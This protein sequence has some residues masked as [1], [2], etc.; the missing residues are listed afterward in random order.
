MRVRTLLAAT[1]TLSATLVAPIAAQPVARPAPRLGVLAGAS[2]A[3]LSGDPVDEWGNRTGFVAGAALT[4]PLTS[5]VSFQPEVLFAQKGAALS[6]DGFTATFKLDY[7]EVPLLL[8]VDMPTTGSA[9]RP[10]LFAGPALAFKASCDVEASGQGVSA[11]RPCRDIANEEDEEDLKSFDAGLMLGGALG[12]DIGR[13]RLN[14]G[15]RYTLGLTKL[16]SADDV[17]N[18][19]ITLYGSLDFPLGR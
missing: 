17:R 14:V 10:H 11:S 9:V 19:A 4:V 2:I 15:A 1:V 16:V 7:V 6:E 12:F 8:R 18:R 3:T 5:V 13:Q